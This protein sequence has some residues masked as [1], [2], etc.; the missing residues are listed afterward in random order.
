MPSPEIM[1]EPRPVPGRRAPERRPRPPAAS[2]ATTA[3]AL[4]PRDDGE[5][6]APLART[7]GWIASSVVLWSAWPLYALYDLS[8]ALDAEDAVGLERRIDFVSVR[9]GLRDDLRVMLGSS[10]LGELAPDRTVDPLIT[11]RAIVALIRSARLNDRGSRTWKAGPAAASTCCASATP[12]SPAGRSRS[13]STSSPDTDSVRR[14]LVLLFRWSGD[15][16]LTRVFLPGD[17][18][19]NTPPACRSGSC[20]SR[21]HASAPSTSAPASAEAPAGGENTAAAMRRRVMLYGRGSVRTRT[22]RAIRA[23]WSG[24]PNRPER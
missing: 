4:R 18:F 5:E 3:A 24:A 14:P 15:W 10:R 20:S 1:I 7:L 21:P 17:A 13:A 19:G 8:S 11:Q 12:S 2:S 22:A 9:Q 23:G 16:R 6:A